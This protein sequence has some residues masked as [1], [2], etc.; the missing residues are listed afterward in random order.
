MR[1][2]MNA[3]ES[4]MC[5]IISDARTLGFTTRM[6]STS[7]SR[8][9]SPTPQIVR[10]IFAHESPGFRRT[11]RKKV[12]TCAIRQRSVVSGK[13]GCTKNRTGGKFKKISHITRGKISTWTF[14]QPFL[15][16]LFY[17]PINNRT[18]RMKMMWMRMYFHTYFIYL[19]KNNWTR[20]LIYAYINVSLS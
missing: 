18:M 19:P 9:A 1:V 6:F 10:A 12:E 17:F 8:S 4:R 15:R 5:N 20:T 3:G 2:Y 13:K 14:L 7:F 11:R 16:S